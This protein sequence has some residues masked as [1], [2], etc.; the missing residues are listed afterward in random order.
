MN[1]IL[2]LE[3]LPHRPLA[4]PISAMLREVVAASA[5][6]GIAWFVGGASARDLL[7]THI[8]DIEAARATADVDI[9]ISIR[10]WTGHEAL[11]NTLIASGHF[12]APKG[13]AHRLNFRTPHTGE[14]SWL[15]IVPFGGVQDARGEIAWPPDQ[16]VRMN[17]AGFRQALDAALPVRIAADLVVPVA[18]LPAQAM[19]KIIAWQD[20]HASDRKD[21]IDLLFLMA[22]YAQAG[23][24]DRLYSDAFD[25]VE[26]HGHDPD[27]AGA[28][29]LGRDTAALAAGEVRARMLAILRSDD[30]APP[31][32]AHMLGARMPVFE[33]DTSERIA[34]LFHAFR[35]ALRDAL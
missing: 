12:D 13:S 9:G 30:P 2:P 32:L 14:R 20:R 23:N 31:I 17:V 24:L 29:L 5:V 28:A 10:S 18:S 35:D 16:S 1:A 6:N 3:L 15:D 34:A 21:A 11:R 25:L 7:L 22:R 8:H 19:L 27:I 4:V 33:D 26:R